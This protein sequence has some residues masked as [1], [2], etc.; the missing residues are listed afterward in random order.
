MCRACEPGFR[1]LMR[2]GLSRRD[3]A[4]SAAAFVG[5]AVAGEATAAAAGPADVIFQGGTVLTQDARW[6]RVTALAVRGDRILAVGSTEH[7]AAHRGARTRIIDLAGRTLAPGFVEPHM[8]GTSVF[9]DDW[10]D[11]SPFTTATVGEALDKVRAEAARTPAG[12]W[13]RGQ[14][15]DPAL[16]PGGPITLDRLDAAAPDHPLILVEGNGHV[17][18]ANR[19]ALALAKV[20]ETTP[21]PPQGRIIRDA[22][23]RLTGRFEEPPAMGLLLRIL[24][25]MGLAEYRRRLRRLLDKAATVGCTSLHDCGVGS[26]YQGAELDALA[27]VMKDDPPVRYSA[28]L[29][30]NQM[31]QWLKRG[32]TPGAGDDLFRV[33]AMKLFSDGSNQGRTGLQHEPY[34]GG[35][36][37]G[38]AYVEPADLT[39]IVVQRALQGWQVVIHANGDLAIDRALDAIEAAQAAGCDPDLRFRIEHCSILHDEQ[40]A[41]IARLG[42]SPS[43]L[44]GHVH[45]WGRAFRDEIFGPEKSD[46]L[47]RAASCGKAGVR[48][49]M[50]SDE[51]V[52]E[53]GPLR[54]ID[55]AVNRSLWQAPGQVLN[56]AECVSVEQAIIALTRDAAWQCHSEHEIGSLEPGKF[57]DFVVLDA[58]PREVPPAE[59]GAIRVLE[60]W[61]GGRQ[62]YAAD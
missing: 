40:I 33:T 20:D 46:L 18:Y 7:V 42:V 13:I 50:H 26:I 15:F 9:F 34:L 32:L 41:R 8:H 5:L 61:V 22:D 17:A 27:A 23:G 12:A 52:T 38:M 3:M 55:N 56:P 48:W 10:L 37:A 60:T 11:L 24:P 2:T 58:D 47:G 14:G 31:D 29:V 16:Q 4:R 45:Y 54:L 28:A 49:T 44:I 43:F 19:A 21:D 25:Q 1:A 39:A 51:P 35:E 59:I 6:P 36:S 62:V 30:S 57:A 53:M